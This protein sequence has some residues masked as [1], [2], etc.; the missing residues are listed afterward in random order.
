MALLLA[1][2]QTLG[3]VRFTWSRRASMSDQLPALGALKKI[4]VKR[5][6]GSQTDKFLWKVP[7]ASYVNDELLL[8]VS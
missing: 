7:V 1:G 4:R 6:E 8:E 2:K 3:K 5:E